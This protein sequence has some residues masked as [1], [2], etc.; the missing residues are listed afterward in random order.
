M[1]I[2][3]EKWSIYNGKFWSKN[4]SLFTLLNNDWLKGF[5]MKIEQKIILDQMPNYS[6]VSLKFFVL[7]LIIT[8]EKSNKKLLRKIYKILTQT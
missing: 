3:L 7:I 8:I 2:S 4:T 1:E 5:A 6:L